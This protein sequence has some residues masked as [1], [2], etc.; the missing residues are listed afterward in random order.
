MSSPR[1]VPEIERL[2]HDYVRREF[3]PDEGDATLTRTTSLI[4]GGILSSIS[5]VKLVSHLEN[6]FGVR[7]AAHEIGEEHLDTVAA[8]ASRIAGKL[9]P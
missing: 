4:G 7:F 1:D 6:R 2:V 5:L 3:L 8:I 9:A